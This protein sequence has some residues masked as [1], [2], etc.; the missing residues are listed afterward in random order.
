MYDTVLVIFC[1]IIS[2]IDIKTLKI[3]DFLLLCCFA[4]LLTHDILNKNEFLYEK[5]SAGLACFV[6]FFAIRY[7]SGGL[8]FG[9]VKYAAL[10]GFALGWKKISFVFLFTAGSAIIIYLAGMKFFG[11]SKWT[12]LPF[13]PFLALGVIATRFVNITI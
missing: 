7:F 6:L 8:G 12:K 4:L 11:W 2:V 13:A 5:L 10:L 3:P 1:L 9:D